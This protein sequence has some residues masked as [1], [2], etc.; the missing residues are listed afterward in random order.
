MSNIFH[1]R[2]DTCDKIRLPTKLYVND[3]DDNVIKVDALEEF[4]EMTPCGAANNFYSSAGARTDILT[5]PHS[6][7]VWSS[8]Q[9]AS[10]TKCKRICLVGMGLVKRVSLMMKSLC[11]RNGNGSC[12]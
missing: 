7:E 2:Y 3:L 9:I 12:E 6:C 8:K 4:E 1:V 10:Q 11:G 5:F